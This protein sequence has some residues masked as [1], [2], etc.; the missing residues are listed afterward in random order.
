MEFYLNMEVIR[1]N[2]N[3]EQQALEFKH[4]ELLNG[5]KEKEEQL[6]RLNKLKEDGK[7]SR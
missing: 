7:K 6:N 5:L 2:I 4:E 1:N 3:R